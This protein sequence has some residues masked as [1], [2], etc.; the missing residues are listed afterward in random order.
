MPGRRPA[1]VFPPGEFLK[2]ELEERGWTQ[3]DLADIL[4]RPVTL[5]NE[6]IVGKRGISP[7]TARGLSAALGTSAELWMNLDSV[8]QL[9]RVANDPDDEIARRAKVYGFA[10]VKDLVRRGWI[11]PSNNVAVLE[12][13]LLGFYQCKSLEERPQFPHAARKS[14]SYEK[15]LTSGQ[16]AWLFR[17]MH[18]ARTISAKRFSKENLKSSVEQLRLYLQ[19]PQEIRHVPRVLSE[20][21][22]RLVVVQPLPG[23]KIDGACFWLDKSPVIA[24]SCRFDR[25]DNFWFVLMHELGHV[26]NDEGSFDEDLKEGTEEEERPPSEKLADQFAV[27]N[28]LSQDALES[29][30]ARI[31]PLYSVQRIEAFAR[32]AKV[33]PGIVVGQLQ[34]RQE[35]TYS[36][37]RKTLS[38]VR[39]IVTKSAITDGWGSTL[40]PDL[41]NQ[42]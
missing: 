29:F 3:K 19:A 26:M 2:D 36:S 42:T 40:P 34:H 13:R 9:S 5:V 14:T 30:I 41:Y 20:A 23:S 12:E 32:V 1:E 38:P 11:E 31:R 27:D 15:T 4:S 7:E 6:I 39:D 33:H 25:I 18:L 22:V 28:I 24:L 16:L 10:P 21:G 37:F 8:Y 17:A 35:I